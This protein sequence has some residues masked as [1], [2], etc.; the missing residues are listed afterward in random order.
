MLEALIFDLDGTLFDSSEANV[1]AYKLA[2]AAANVDFDEHAYRSNFGLRY[3]EMM[4]HIAPAASS[5]QRDTIKAAKA[6][7]YQDNL[8]LVTKNDGLLALLQTVH[9]S[10]KTALVTTAAKPN[11]DN[12]LN[13]FA[14]DPALF[15]VIVYGHEVT[16]GK[17]DPEGYKLA[18]KRLEV[19]PSA[20]CI[21][22]DSAVGLEA[23]R[24]SGAH[25]VQ[26]HL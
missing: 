22:E 17:P 26:V 19:E 21:F 8:E 18:M 16:N 24:A 9:G 12:L 13:H 3:A 23:A 10:L 20:V 15:D 11:V 2:F 5:Q 7:F 6:G 25:V 4:D 14:V 1:V